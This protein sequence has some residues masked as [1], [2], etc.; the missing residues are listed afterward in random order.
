MILD[1]AGVQAAHTVP[2]L[3]VGLGVL[4]LKGALL[5]GGDHGHLG[6]D[7]GEHLALRFGIDAV[8][9][10]TKSLV[11][12]RPERDAIGDTRRPRHRAQAGDVLVCTLPSL[13]RVSIRLNW[14]RSPFSRKRTNM[15]V[16]V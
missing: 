6:V 15:V 11:Q 7:G 2:E 5:V 14:S 13:R 9:E 16:V 4:Q 12:M 10:L 8:R 3:H 1:R